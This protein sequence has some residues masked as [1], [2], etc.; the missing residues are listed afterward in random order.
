MWIYERIEL[1][2]DV[3]I[4]RGSDLEEEI[5]YPLVFDKPVQV[6]KHTGWRYKIYTTPL[7][8]W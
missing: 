8:K 6:G 2:L 5:L 1:A 7:P 4:D 3:E